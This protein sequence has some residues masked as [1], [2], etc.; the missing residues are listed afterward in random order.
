MNYPFEAQDGSGDQIELDFPMREAPGFDT[1]I[2]HE[3][4]AWKR[5]ITPPRVF[6]EPNASGPSKQLPPGPDGKPQYCAN[7]HEQRDAAARAGFDVL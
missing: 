6:V 3:G 7:R 2:E 1:V 5:V 4:R